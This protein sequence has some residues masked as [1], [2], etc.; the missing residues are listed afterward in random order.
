MAADLDIEVARNAAFLR[1]LTITDDDGAPIDLT[2]ASFALDVRS[3]A[4]V[5]SVLASA[6]VTVDDA[7]NGLLTIELLGSAFSGVTGTT[8][9]VRLAHD[10]LATQDSVTIALVRGEIV[11][12]PAV[13]DA[14]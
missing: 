9:I 1:Q 13:S 14:P 5:G 3:A 6:T 11:L 10:F 4:G 7:P 12:L 2:G 8:E